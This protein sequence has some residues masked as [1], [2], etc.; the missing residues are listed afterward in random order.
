[1]KLV[2]VIFVLCRV[3]GKLRAWYRKKSLL[4]LNRFGMAN[5]CLKTHR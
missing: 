2:P 1:M 3:T 5:F 4:V